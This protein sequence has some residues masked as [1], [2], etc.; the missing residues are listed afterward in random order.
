MT[1]S[2]EKWF[3]AV[4]HSSTLANQNVAV[5]LPRRGEGGKTHVTLCPFHSVC[6][7]QLM[8]I[9]T[10][11]VRAFG[12]TNVFVVCLVCLFI[13]FLVCFFSSFALLCTCRQFRF[14]RWSLQFS[15]VQDIY[16][17]GKSRMRPTPFLRSYPK[18]DFE[19][20]WNGCIFVWL[21]MAFSRPFEEDRL[22]TFDYTW[23]NTRRFQHG[24]VIPDSCSTP[25]IKS[26]GDECINKRWRELNLI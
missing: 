6:T 20:L 5:K 26:D 22:A 23:R 24:F 12:S 14:Y 10:G 11:F 21:T 18:V 9:A 4:N 3:G 13:C 15:S 25:L 7:S 17:L 8:T 19:T 2:V 1:P 16:A